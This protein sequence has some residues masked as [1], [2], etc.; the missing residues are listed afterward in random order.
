MI[1][2]NS[3]FVPVNRGHRS[4]DE[5]RNFCRYTVYDNRTDFPIIVDGTAVECASALGRSRDSFYCLVTRVQ[6][7]KNKRYTILRRMMDEEEQ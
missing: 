3:G 1:A 6:Q 7:G 4:V 2:V 5:L